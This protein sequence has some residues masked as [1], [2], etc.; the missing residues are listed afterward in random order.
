M[1]CELAHG[2]FL[3]D[4]LCKLILS[5]PDLRLRCDPVCWLAPGLGPLLQGLLPEVREGPG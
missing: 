4:H 1:A 3:P 2:P 5:L